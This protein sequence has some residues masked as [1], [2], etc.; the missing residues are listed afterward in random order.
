[1]KLTQFSMSDIG[2][3]KPFFLIAGAC[4]IK[5]RDMV[6]DVCGRLVEITKRARWKSCDEAVTSQPFLG[7]SFNS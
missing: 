2:L 1:M 5:S 6:S 3:N 7:D 4:V